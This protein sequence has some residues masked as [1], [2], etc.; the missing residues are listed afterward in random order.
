MHH[1]AHDSD[2]LRETLASTIAVDDFTAKLFKIFET[3]Q[4]EG[5]TQ[6]SVALI[7]HVFPSSLH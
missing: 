6:V 7:H 2:F 4:A 5:V 3:V 1:V